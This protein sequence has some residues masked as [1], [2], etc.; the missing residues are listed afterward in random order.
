[1]SEDEKNRRLEELF[2]EL[3]RNGPL[4]AKVYYA[5]IL[6]STINYDQ[7][8]QRFERVLKECSLGMVINYENILDNL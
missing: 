3:L 8:I 4:E 7:V 5:N 1:M 2:R 6:S